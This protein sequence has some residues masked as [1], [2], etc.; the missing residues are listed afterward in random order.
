MYTAIMVYVQQTD[1]LI[2]D[3]WNVNTL[4]ITWCLVHIAQAT[5]Y[6]N[7][8]YAYRTLQWHLKVRIG[9]VFNVNSAT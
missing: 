3:A 4:L 2:M 1:I 5:P 9:T 7:S 8:H 6:Y